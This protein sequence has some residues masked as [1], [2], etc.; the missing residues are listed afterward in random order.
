MHKIKHNYNLSLPVYLYVSHCIVLEFLKSE[1]IIS[2]FC[3]FFRRGYFG[4]WAVERIRFNKPCGKTPCAWI[5]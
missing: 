1:K 3:H 2:Y 4:F 5:I